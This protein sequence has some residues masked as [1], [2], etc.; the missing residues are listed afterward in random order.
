MRKGGSWGRDG[1]M[2]ERKERE[3][4][5][6]KKEEGRERERTGAQSQKKF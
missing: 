5:K 1:E 2:L 4:G 3:R 6:R